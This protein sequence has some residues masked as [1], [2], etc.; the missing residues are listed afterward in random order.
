MEFVCPIYGA[1]VPE[2]ANTFDKAYDYENTKWEE[3]FGRISVETPDDKTNDVIRA[4]M[5]HM[6]WWLVHGY[7]RHSPV[8]YPLYWL[9]DAA[10]MNNLFDKFGQVST[11]RFNSD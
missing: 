7:W 2:K 9:R 11:T 6:R 10:L 1:K 5:T 8:T 4:I 3:L